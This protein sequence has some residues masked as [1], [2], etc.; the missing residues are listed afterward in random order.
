MTPLH[1]L[2]P[3][4]ILLFALACLALFVLGAG[5][6]APASGAPFGGVP[7]LALETFAT[8]LNNPVDIAHAGDNRLFVVEQAGRI[9]I[10]QSNGTVLSTPFLDISGLVLAPG[11]PG[12]NNEQGLLGLAFDPNYATNGYFYVNYTRVANVSDNQGDTVI[13]RYSVSNSDP[14]V[15]DPNSEVKI[16][17]VDQPYVNHNG[18]DLNFGPDGYLYIGLG[19]GGLGGDPENRAQNGMQLLGKMLRIDVHGGGQP[20][21]CGNN[22]NYTIPADNP[23]INDPGVCNEIWHFGLR[24]PWRFS[25]D[26]LTGDMYI[27]DV[28]QADREEVNF[29]PAS[30]AGGENWG[31][32]CYEG[33]AQFNTTG[34]GPMGN[35]DFPFHEYSHAS[36]NC[37]VTGGYVYRGG[38]YPLLYGHYLFTDY[39][40]GQV[41]TAIN[42]GGWQVTPQ[43]DLGNSFTSF[44]EGSNGEIYLASS[45]GTIYHVIETTTFQ[46]PTPTPTPTQPINLQLVATGFVE[47]VDVTNAGDARLFVAERAGYIYEVAPNGSVQSQPLL[48]ISSKVTTAYYE[49]GLLSFTFDPDFYN[50]GYLYTYYTDLNEDLVISRFTVAGPITGT[51]PLPPVDLDTELLILS[52]DRPD[53]Y[54]KNNNNNGGELTFNADGYLFVSIGDGGVHE[55]AQDPLS[56][57]GK[58]LRIDVVGITKTG[59]RPPECGTGNYTVPPGNPFTDDANA[60]D[61]IWALGFRNPWRF[62]FDALFTDLYLGD[63]GSEQAEEVNYQPATSTGGENYGWSCYEGTQ[64]SEHFNAATCTASYTDPIH[65]TG[66]K[67]VIGGYVYRGC[68]FA[69]MEGKYYFADFVF[70][71]LASLEQDGG[72]GWQV[73]TLLSSAGS[74]SSFGEG[75]DGELYLLDYSG[76]LYHLAGNVPG[77]CFWSDFIHLPLIGKDFSASP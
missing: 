55:N 9:K 40:S 70:G 5:L 37:S 71:S 64:P 12:G 63:V 62:S 21:D 28:G 32:R 72:G 69:D 65:E 2:H 53:N 17:V 4:W 44:G 34:C 25:F 1:K 66:G 46:T 30:S 7:D 38:Q 13:A 14:N 41:W 52:V 16:L 10:V 48:D 23:F 36:G 45:N 54:P 57:L 61:E 33:S 77:S 3:F 47:P 76:A 8:G 59:A 49:Q 50:N 35:Y 18:G 60:C 27:G 42:D 68:K 15:A 58:L 43:G 20:S 24:N 39:C 74:F 22:T 56:L 19:D 67:A 29:Q 11:D 6:S 51:V 26:S 75:F 31:W 73:E